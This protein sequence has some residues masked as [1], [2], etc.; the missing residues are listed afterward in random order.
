MYDSPALYTTQRTAANPPF[1]TETDLSGN[2]PFASPWAYSSNPTINNG[3]TGWNPYPLTQPPT[4]AAVFPLKTQWVMVPTTSKIPVVY[5][6]TAS[7]QQDLGKGWSASLNYLG[8]E[9]AHFWLGQAL[10]PAVYI[11][12]T[13]SGAG[14]CGGMVT[15]GMTI[16][17]NCSTTAAGNY[18]QRSKL[19]LANTT[20]NAFSNYW[21]SYYSV[22]TSTMIFNGATSSYNDLIA[23]LQHRMSHNYS[24]LLNYTYS[25]AIDTGDA[26]GDIA[27]NSFMDPNNPRLDRGNAGFDIRHIINA[28][29]VDRSNFKFTNRTLNALVNGWEL[30]PLLRILSGAPF[31]VTS[32]SDISLNDMGLDRP[33]VV[34]GQSFTTGQKV[35]SSTTNGANRTFFNKN[36]FSTSTVTAGTFG[37]AGRNILRGPKYFDLDASLNRTIKVWNKMD[38]NVRLEAFN[39]T[40]HPFFS[41]FTTAMSSSSFG[42]ATAAGDPRIMQ[43][44][45]KF[46]F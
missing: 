29:V 18:Y 25:H 1:A 44:A 14:S 45:V 26:P 15:T 37:N 23:T 31:N 20:A 28:T 33:N 7:I 32:G 17:Q 24:V 27:S 30:A 8:N 36:A 12:G 2:V 40:N 43:A 22:A 3:P 19:T 9:N 39:L 21:G 13:Y 5:Q 11:A 35:Y 42:W 46:N 4:S 34:A 16:G 6:W 38:M 10:N 41:S